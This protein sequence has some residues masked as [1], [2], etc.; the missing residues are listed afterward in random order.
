MSILA[1]ILPK[2]NF[3]TS[4]SKKEYY[5]QK[6][7]KSTDIP[8]IL[9]LYRDSANIIS[10]Q[11]NI[12]AFEIA[13]GSSTTFVKK[14]M[15]EPILEYQCEALKERKIFI[16]KS[17]FLKTKV[18]TQFHFYNKKLFIVENHFYT[19]NEAEQNIF[20]KIF[21]EKYNL[22]SKNLRGSFKLVDPK[23]NNLIVSNE[24]YT[25]LIYLYN[26]KAILK[27]LQEKHINKSLKDLNQYQLHI[28]SWQKII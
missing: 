21:V 22:S 13:L 23:G 27:D 28:S 6:I 20:Q 9:A 3:S 26:N 8:E 10:V 16:Y 19:M 12:K 11:N 18:F 2:L 24:L 4:S 14:Q 5:E 17:R 1:N 15:G 7:T 25:S